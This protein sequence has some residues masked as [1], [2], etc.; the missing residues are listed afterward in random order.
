MITPP[1]FNQVNLVVRDMERSLEF[2]RAAGMNVGA[3]PEWPPG[4][5]CRHAEVGDDATLEWDNEQ[6]LRV[7]APEVEGNVGPGAGRLRGRRRGGAA[8]SASPMS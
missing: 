7:W 1:R 3:G 2:Y 5:G 4:S 6:F 8:A